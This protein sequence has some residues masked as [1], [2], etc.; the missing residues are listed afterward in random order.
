MTNPINL[1]LSGITPNQDI[2]K[3]KKEKTESKQEQEV[4]TQATNKDIDEKEIFNFMNNTGNIA[5]VNVKQSVQ[6]LINRYNSPEAIKRIE[7]MMEEFEDGVVQG[8][9]KFEA[10]L[11]GTA[12]YRSLSETN[13]LN[14]AAKLYSEE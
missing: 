7:A 11:G 3:K 6:A 4:T 8:L 5:K 9:A 2:E 14:L 10:E 13:K 12:Q 1:N